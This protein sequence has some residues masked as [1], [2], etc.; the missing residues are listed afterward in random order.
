MA[1]YEMRTDHPCRDCGKLT[2]YFPHCL[3]CTFETWRPEADIAIP[4]PNLR[5]TKARRIESNEQSDG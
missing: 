1:S 5:R 3:A 4:K 2:P